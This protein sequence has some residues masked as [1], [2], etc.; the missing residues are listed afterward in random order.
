MDPTG[1][2]FT[3]LNET[4]PQAQGD[5]AM[6]EGIQ[7]PDLALHSGD[8]RAVAPTGDPGFDPDEGPQGDPWQKLQELRTELRHC[9]L[10]RESII[11]G[12]LACLLSGHHAL[13]LGPP[14]TAKS[15]LILELCRSLQGA[16]FFNRLLQKAM[17]PE[18]ILGQISLKALQ[19]E[20]VLRR[21]TQSRLPRA[22]IGF[23]DEIFKCNP[24]VL[25]ALLRLIQERVFENPDPQPVPLR[26]LVGASNE[27]PSDGEL[28]A[29]A[30]RFTY[31]P[32][33]GYLRSRQSRK[34]LLQRAR[35]GIKPQV[36]VQIT[37]MELEDLQHRAQEV[38]V[39][40]AL[41]EAAMDGVE[42]LGRSAFVISDRKLQQLLLLS[43]AYAFVQ[44]DGEVMI[45]H[46]HELWPECI[47]N[48]PQERDE[49]RSILQ[50][51]CP[52]A[53][54]LCQ[55]LYEAARQEMNTLM[56]NAEVMRNSRRNTSLS[57]RDAQALEK[58]YRG[59]LDKLS[60]VLETTRSKMQ[61]AVETY[62]GRRSDKTTR[63]IQA[64]EELM[65]E[66][67]RLQGETHGSR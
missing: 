27:Y 14:G 30:D 38:A 26:F 12:L 23:L 6:A 28:L 46:L 60:K 42:K 1:T 33:V 44:G 56:S 61:L 63:L 62:T 67:D 29:F 40:D 43:K 8:L 16:E 21:N 58:M 54:T 10:E 7:S 34:I 22:T 55:Q 52:T 41:L 18:E 37:L 11:D 2:V 64:V 66:V 20:D 36:A 32:W 51:A 50:A 17:P 53:T 35:Q 15:A 49:I 9:F 24:T 45:D 25:N 31:K 47:W 5:L 59:K 57:S 39:T 19:Q 4:G 65:A 3:V 48:R 13:L